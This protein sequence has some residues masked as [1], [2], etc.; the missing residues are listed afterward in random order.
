M[1]PTLPLNKDKESF[2]GRRIKDGIKGGA[3]LKMEKLF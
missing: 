1:F 2:N 3:L